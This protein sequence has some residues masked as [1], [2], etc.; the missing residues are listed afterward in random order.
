MKHLKQFIMTTKIATS[1]FSKI[2]LLS[3]LLFSENCF[4]QIGSIWT[5]ISDFSKAGIRL[6][7]GNLVSSNSDINTL[8]TNLNITSI[9]QALPSSRNEG[10]KNV[11][12]ITCNCDE[13]DLLQQVARLSAV[14]SK[15][16]I[17][18][19]YELL[20]TPNDYSSA[21][22]SDYALNLINA[23]DAWG[24]TTGD[25]SVIIGI[26]DSNFDLNHE[27]LIGKYSYV[28]L[29]NGNS[30]YYHGTAVAVTAAG[31]TNNLVGKS[32]IGYN[33]SL[34][35]RA[36]NYNEL[37][38]ATYSG[39]KVINVSWTS[40]CYDNSYSQEVIDEVYNNGTVVV[41]SAGNGST[42][43]GPANLVYPAAHNHVIA[44]SSVGPLDNHERTIGDA[45]TTHQHNS[46]VDLCAPGYDVALTVSAGWYLTGNG[47]SFAAPYV[48]GT[49]A[50]MFAVNPCL[51]P[52]N[53]EMIL[54]QTAFNLDSINP[55]Y[56]GNLGAG[57]LDAFAAVQ[58]ASTYNVMTITSSSSLDCSTFN[59]E[60]SLQVTGG[61]APYTVVWNTNEIGM[62]IPNA[63]GDF[64]YTAFVS[65]SN[66]CVV[67]HTTSVSAIS[68][69][70]FDTQINNVNC[71]GETSGSI[72]MEVSGSTGVYSFLW[73]TGETTE[74]LY[75][76][77]IGNY[78]VN[79]SDGR[80]C[81]LFAD[82]TITE[83]TDLTASTVHQNLTIATVGSIDLT[84]TGGT[85]PYSYSW[86]NG[87]N[88]E[89][90][91]NLTP[92][93]YEVG[94]TDSHG[95]LVSTNVIVLDNQHSENE[96]ILAAI[97]IPTESANNQLNTIPT[98]GTMG[99][100][101]IA[102]HAITVYPN[103]AIGVTHIEW[104]GLEV[105]SLELID[106]TGQ[107]V[108]TTVINSI[109]SNY[110]LNQERAGEYFVKMNLTN[111][112]SVVKKVTFI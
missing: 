7:T 50:L 89:D 69:L 28:T 58:M 43:G 66:G 25:S 20:N 31:R 88:N 17:A 51:T 78:H 14:F 4:S 53:V 10:L 35:L 71:N 105:T 83:P 30:N 27:E 82:F 44:V 80:G 52:D 24:I 38:E 6:E 61:Y 33:S 81:N 91:T 109:T 76:L 19:K 21:F 64:Q 34:Q 36:M 79:I 26:S 63:Q 106:M 45:A 97:Y 95:C 48:S 5:T 1:K 102:E 42:C 23:Q 75:N 94:I 56:A 40:G 92:G 98:E 32:S 18:P 74:D 12:E 67:K 84:V 90:L 70:T 68:P 57:R 107:I 101:E 37:L 62:N 41:V 59:Q 47:T 49:V 29:G 112:S 39:A 13:N 54:K 93:F 16:E 46:S 22:A 111:G 96:N 99:I 65:D 108:S 103:P 87:M 77:G 85:F 72:E 3:T 2:I 15:P 86:N 100:N 110:E 104:S 9:T 11:Y 8:I 73:S 60:I 55:L